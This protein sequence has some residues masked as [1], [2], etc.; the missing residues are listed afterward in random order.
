[1]LKRLRKSPLGPLITFHEAANEIAT[2]LNIPFE[3][4]IMTLYGLCI[5][6]GVRWSFVGGEIVELHEITAKDFSNKPSCIE[7]E[8]IRYHLAEWSTQPQRLQRDQVIFELLREGLNPPRSIDWK[9][10]CDLVRNKCKGW[11]KAGKPAFSFGDKQIQ[12]VVKEL[13]SK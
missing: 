3:A 8:D 9:S 11:L 2:A 7:A 13:R 10:F 6:G 4:A 1:M 12:R 5:T